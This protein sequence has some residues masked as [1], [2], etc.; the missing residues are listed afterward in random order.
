M[1]QC[2]EVGTDTD[3]LVSVSSEAIALLSLKTLL[4]NTARLALKCLSIGI[5]VILSKP[6]SA[7]LSC[8]CSFNC[9]DDFF[10]ALDAAW[11]AQSKV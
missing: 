10:K 7:L 11:A 2:F 3:T 6:F 4:K 9:V 8:F 5:R 1:L